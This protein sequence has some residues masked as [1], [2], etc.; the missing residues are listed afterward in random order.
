MQGRP[1]EQVLSPDRVILKRHKD[2]EPLHH[3]VD[4]VASGSFRRRKPPEI[5]GH[6]YVLKS[7]EAALWAFHAT[8]TSATQFLRR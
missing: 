4:A 2:A 1:R 7:L 3:E 8:M 6:G 5:S